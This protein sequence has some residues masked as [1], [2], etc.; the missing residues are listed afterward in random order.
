[1]KQE[2][3]VEAANSASVW[4][5]VLVTLKEH[6]VDKCVKVYD[7]ATDFDALWFL[8]QPSTADPA[9][10]ATLICWDGFPQA[11]KSEGDPRDYASHL[12]PY[13]WALVDACR[14][15]A[16]GAPRSV[17]VLHG[18]SIL[19]G[20]GMAED[21]VARAIRSLALGQSALGWLRG[22]SLPPLIMVDGHPH[23]CEFETLVELIAKPAAKRGAGNAS[24]GTEFELPADLKATISAMLFSC[25]GSGHA[26][27]NAVGPLVLAECLS[28]TSLSGSDGDNKQTSRANRALRQ[29]LVALHMVPEKPSEEHG[30]ASSPRT[31]DALSLTPPVHRLVDDEVAFV[32][33]L[34][35]ALAPSELERVAAA[36]VIQALAAAEPTGMLDGLGEVLWLDLRLWPTGDKKMRR[37]LLKMILVVLEAEPRWI[38]ATDGET[39][40]RWIERAREAREAAQNLVK[41]GWDSHS[42]ADDYANELKALTLLPLLLSRADPS[43]PIVIFSATRQREVDKRLRI[44]PN[45]VLDFTKPT[46][47]HV[48][49]TAA[50]VRDDFVHA[51]KTAEQLAALRP[52]WRRIVG[53]KGLRKGDLPAPRVGHGLRMQQPTGR[54]RYL[55]AEWQLDGPQTKKR[56]ERLFELA[57]RADLRAMMPATY[58]VLEAGYS[59]VETKR[60]LA[61]IDVLWGA[62]EP[63]TS[64]QPRSVAVRRE[65]AQ[66]LYD[67]RRH[68][69]RGLAKHEDPAYEEVLAPWACAALLWALLEVLLAPSEFMIGWSAPADEDPGASSRT[70]PDSSF[71]GKRLL[72][73]IRI[74]QKNDE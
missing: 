54:Y 62:G 28:N 29:L 39:V 72:D 2:P 64:N 56:L 67:I 70:T 14:R 4:G 8:E 12:T 63:M 1:V 16:Q 49:A 21:R 51:L 61:N 48:M 25:L 73:A 57:T 18:P 58:E 69:V 74:G 59:E 30:I 34:K 26:V 20:G 35:D 11:F 65:L 24:C 5:R 66:A 52:L 31:P 10:A 22:F 15:S 36:E 45:I 55:D 44:C 6:A 50:T 33:V 23:L 19:T 46:V 32:K 42:D 3:M 7:Y 43:L 38:P 60:A 41:T 27:A 13:H 53:L 17:W 47:G 37:D 9:T 71:I 40:D 68:W